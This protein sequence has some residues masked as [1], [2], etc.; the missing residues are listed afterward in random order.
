M[1]RPPRKKRRAIAPKKRLDDT[2]SDTMGDTKLVNAME[3]NPEFFKD[4]LLGKTIGKCTIEKFVGEGKTATVYR[5]H[6]EPLNRTVA[7]KVLLPRMTKV[8]A[9]LKV[10]QQ[11]GRAVAALDHEN[12]LK[13]YDV[14]ESGGFYY[15]VLELLRGKDLLKV[16]E[17][18]E[19]GRLPVEEALGYIKQAARGLAAASRKNLVHRDI[20]P[21]NLVLEPDGT[22][23]IVDFGLA[24][25]AEGAFAGG[26]LGTPH[27]MAPEQ[28]RGETSVH[29]TDIYALGITLFHLLVGQPP[30][31]GRK[32]KEEIIDGHLQGI[33][34][35]PEKIR[36]EIPRSVG[37]IV[38]KMTRMTAADRPTAREVIEL[39]DRYRPDR[40]GE[41]PTMRART[42]RAARAKS[43]PTGLFVVVGAVVLAGVVIA[44]MSGTGDKPNGSNSATKTTP[45]APPKVDP[46]RDQKPPPIV[47]KT[48]EEEIKQLFLDAEAEEE[49]QNDQEAHM[50]YMQIV[51]KAPVGSQWHRS[52][53]KRAENLRDRINARKKGRRIKPRITAKMSRDA[54]EEFRS[55]LEDY[56]AMLKAFQVS[57]VKT[58]IK[59]LITLTRE[60]SEERAE[61]ERYLTRV[62]YMEGLLGMAA[63]RAHSLSGE[64]ASWDYFD[65]TAPGD[66]IVMRADDQGIQLKDQ[67]SDTEELERWDSISPRVLVR[68]FDALRNEDS[69]NHNLWLGYFC[70][71]IEHDAAEIYFDYARLKDSSPAMAEA[72]REITQE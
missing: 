52:A 30:F 71:L 37:E 56:P 70:T 67:E 6:Y 12:V 11:E 7:V 63:G 21:Q 14:G 41:K 3:S 36:K 4:P 59:K 66:L 44:V 53:K 45:V 32:T 1:A 47:P 10:F 49:T 55:R 34:F 43:R 8:P 57:E 69:A 13:I 39:V 16:L 26:R 18:K 62:D 28:G 31:A 27:Y 19:G 58:E 5:A 25:E 20:K 38:R 17:G 33:R 65:H 29:Q 9:V 2:G 35:E 51:Q 48:L 40:P 50:I 68:F 46:K 54:H 60:E 24:A 61:M 23:K 72:I 64:K 15:M 22:L 42:R